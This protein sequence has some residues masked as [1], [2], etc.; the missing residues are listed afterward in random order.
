MFLIFIQKNSRE[1]GKLAQAVT[2]LTNIQ[3]ILHSNIGWDTNYLEVFHIFFSP[4]LI[5]G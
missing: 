1:L 3:V 2:L 4:S 5:P